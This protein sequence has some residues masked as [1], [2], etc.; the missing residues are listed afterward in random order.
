MTVAVA[1][2]GTTETPGP[3]RGIAL[4]RETGLRL[5]VADNPPFVLDVDSGRVTRLPAVRPLSRGVLSVHEVAGRA[6]V[7][8]ARPGPDAVLYGVS[9]RAA[10]VSPLGTGREVAPAADGRSVWVKGVTSR[11]RCTLR[12]VD[13]DGR[14]LRAP[15]PFPCRWRIQPGGP[16]GLVVHR[17]RL[18]DPRTQRTL[19]R[20]RWGVI[21]VAGTRLVTVGPD[22]RFALIDARTGAERRLRWPSILTGLDHPAVDP[23]GRF[24]ALAFADPAR[25]GQQALDVWLLD[26]RTGKLTQLPGMP[27]F[28]ALKQTSMA[29]TDD[30]RLVLLGETRERD[31]VAVWRAGQRRLAVKTVNLPE[32]TSGSDSFAPV[33]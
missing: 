1:A 9:G 11:S 31:F 8:V 16:L 22:K 6:A 15:R 23:R 29:W 21:A 19:L 13:L 7:V 25:G 32:R 30:G 10:R 28:V 24:V 14:Q 26:N 4:G 33:G 20:S 2:G 5:V 12:Q 3:L 27:A 18:I 17:T